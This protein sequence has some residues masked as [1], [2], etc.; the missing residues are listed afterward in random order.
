MAQMALSSNLHALIVQRL[1]MILAKFVCT[2]CAKT[3]ED[4]G[5]NRHSKS[6]WMARLW[7]FS[8]G[9]PKRSFSEEVQRGDQGKFFKHRPK[10]SPRLK[11]PKALW[12]KWHYPLI[13]MRL[14]WK[15]WRSFWRKQRLPKCPN[16]QVM[17]I[18][19]R[20]PKTRIFLKVQRGDLENVFKNRQKSSPRL[21][22]QQ[23]YGA[24]GII[25]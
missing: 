2:Y 1:Q 7:Q 22:G 9:I 5:T 19:A 11:R 20:S 23:H 13:S 18:F 8:Q 17:A 14:N 3:G 6:A 25:L 10:R 15:D 16:G 24:N 21:K 4:F 12:L